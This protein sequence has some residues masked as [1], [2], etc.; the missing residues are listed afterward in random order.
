MVKFTVI[1]L[2]VWLLSQSIIRLLGHLIFNISS[3]L[4]YILIFITIPLV[5]LITYA[6]YDR[7]HL[8]QDMQTKIAGRIFPT[9]LLLEIPIFIYW[10]TLFP[11]MTTNAIILYAAYLFAFYALC[12]LTGTI[13]NPIK[14]NAKIEKTNE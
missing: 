7:L 5:Y 14:R 3:P 12:L 9:F 4:L 2:G 10:E 6:L 1:F 11:N 8:T 13:T